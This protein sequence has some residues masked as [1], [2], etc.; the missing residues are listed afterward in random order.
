MKKSFLLAV[1]PFVA[2]VASAHIQVAEAQQASASA[3]PKSETSRSAIERFND[4]YFADPEDIGDDIVPNHLSG[5]HVA[6]GRQIA[7]EAKRAAIATRKQPVERVEQTEQAAVKPSSSVQQVTFVQGKEGENV[8]LIQG[9]VIEQPS[10]DALNVT[11]PTPNNSVPAF[12]AAP[13]PRE[14]YIIDAPIVAPIESPNYAQPFRETPIMQPQ[15]AVMSQLPQVQS[16]SRGQ[17]SSPRQTF[18]EPMVVETTSLDPYAARMRQ[19]SNSLGFEARPQFDDQMQHV[20]DRFSPGGE[21]FAFS[22]GRADPNFFGVNREECCDEWYGFCNCGGLKFNQGHLGV[23]N[24][25]S[26]EPCEQCGQRIHRQSCRSRAAQP[27]C[28]C[29]TCRN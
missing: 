20:T 12:S 7:V 3:Q 13:V 14:P 28:G 5:V 16:P 8:Q 18:S 10:A 6:I 27:D 2:F 25:R 29:S 26:N 23:R 1:L 19:R 9:K 21:P 24:L 11:K 17:L 4:S 22:V 15:A